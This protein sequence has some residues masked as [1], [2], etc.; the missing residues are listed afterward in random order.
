M[1]KLLIVLLLAGCSSA[2][3]SGEMGGGKTVAE[4]IY[5]AESQCQKSGEFNDA[6]EYNACVDNALGDNQEA[7]TKLAERAARAR[8]EHSTNGLSEID[9]TCE[10]YGHVIGTEQYDVCVDYAKENQANTG[11]QRKH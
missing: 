3:L 4:N 7:K 9:R 5:Q 6:S 2:Q 10:R 11:N 1:H 8:N